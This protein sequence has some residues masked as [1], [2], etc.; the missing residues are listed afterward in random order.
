MG[1][2]SITAASCG[3]VMGVALDDNSSR[4][5]YRADAIMTQLPTMAA[6]AKNV[7]SDRSCYMGSEWNCANGWLTGRLLL[8]S[9][10]DETATETNQDRKTR[11]RWP[12][13]RITQTPPVVPLFDRYENCHKVWSAGTGELAALIGVKDLRPAIEVQGLVYRVNAE[14]HGERDRQTQAKTR[15]ANQSMTPER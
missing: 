1:D 8:P 15:H 11:G 10:A 9:L 3:V 12:N 5:E 7:S 14:L 4:L 6:V 2:S 13:R